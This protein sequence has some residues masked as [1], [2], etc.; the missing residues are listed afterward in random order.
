MVDTQRTCLDV[1]RGRFRVQSS[2][3]GFGFAQCARTNLC[4]NSHFLRAHFCSF[5]ER[6]YFIS[7]QTLRTLLF[8]FMTCDFMAGDTRA[9]VTQN[10]GRCLPKRLP[11]IIGL[12][13]NWERDDARLTTH[14]N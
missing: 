6:I 13:R 2:E 4:L 5:Y 8:S 11:L 10:I 9:Q 3:S 7:T 14:R 12:R 1:G